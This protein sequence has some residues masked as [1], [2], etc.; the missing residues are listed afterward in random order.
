M[1]KGCMKR[2]LGLRILD[3]SILVVDD[4][5]VLNQQLLC[6][7]EW[8]QE[9]PPR[10]YVMSE[11]LKPSSAIGQSLPSLAHARVDLHA[12]QLVQVI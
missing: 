5:V 2:A 11:L 3:A 7:G 12:P 1:R 8:K 6:Y 10:I 9:L 4:C